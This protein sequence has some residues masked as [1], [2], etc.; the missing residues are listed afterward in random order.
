M[1]GHFI[2]SPIMV[3]TSTNGHHF[4]YGPYVWLVISF[5]NV[6][7]LFLSTRSMTPVI[8]VTHA[9]LPSPPP[10]SP[11]LSKRSSSSSYFIS[12]MMHSCLTGRSIRSENKAR[13]VQC[14]KAVNSV[15]RYLS[16]R[17]FSSKPIKLRRWSHPPP[18][19]TTKFQI[20][21]K[22][23]R[24]NKLWSGLRSLTDFSDC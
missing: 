18:R 14:Q 21:S 7:H 13:S 19:D 2:M 9:S 22:C 17:P 8:T 5:I 24:K 3:P 10:I 12:R 1:I 20:V 15:L 6:S 23:I 11:S 4:I 16:K